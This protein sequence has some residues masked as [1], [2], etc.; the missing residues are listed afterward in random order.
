[1][2]C[3]GR[4]IALDIARGLYSLHSRRIV[5][6]DVKSPNILLTRECLAKIADVGL[7][8]P[9]LSQYSHVDQTG[10]IKGTWAWQVSTCFHLHAGGCP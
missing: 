3:R 10:A 5:H 6:M 7:A 9:L 8:H 1:M 4:D 2:H